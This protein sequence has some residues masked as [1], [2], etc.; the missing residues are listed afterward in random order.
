MNV[1]N[2]M[3]RFTRDPELRY[4]QTGKAVANFTLAVKGYKKDEVD[5]INCLAWDKTAELIGEYLR[6][7][8]LLAIEGNIKTS[9]YEKDGKKNYKTEVNVGKIHFCGGKKNDAAE[10]NNKK[11]VELEDEFPF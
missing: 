11:N 2:L 1:V 9:T 8:D 5:F 10:G 7:G 3:G 4:T 6:K